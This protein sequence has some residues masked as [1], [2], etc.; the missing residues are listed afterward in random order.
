MARFQADA[1][2]RLGRQIFMAVGTPEDAARV[3]ADSLVDASLAGH[4]S[5]GVLR[6]PQY[7]K[8]V[9]D[10]EIDPAARPKILSERQATA[11]MSGE[12]GFGQPAGRAA[13]VEAVRRAREFG[14]GA[15]G[16]VRINHLGRLGEYGELAAADGCVAM[17][18]LGGLEQHAVPYGGTRIAIGTN[19]LTVGFPIEG[20]P[21]ALLDFATTAAAAGKLMAARDAGKPVPPGWTVD[22]R[23][24]PTTDPREYF[25]GGALL[26]AGHKGYALAVLLDLVGQALTGAEQY[27]G[28]GGIE[29]ER[30]SGALFCAVDAASFRPAG[31]AAAAGRRI[32]DRLRANPPAE[33]I[34]RVMT[35]GEPE[36]RTRAARNARG[37][38]LPEETWRALI[39]TAKS[40]GLSPQDLPRPVSGAS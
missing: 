40:V 27:G 15:V 16:L 18:W 34:E 20:E 35:P 2:H 24:R 26:P 7:V 37:I 8:R 3:V 22:S 19:P 31:E 6:I 28:A 21:P 11:L 23:G 4:D 10:R 36:V 9:R 17:V 1:L 29:T 32:V 33:G 38:E 12:W 13:I 5:H 30:R 25:A 14:V 39:E